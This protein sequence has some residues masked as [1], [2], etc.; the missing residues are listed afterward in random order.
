MV[1]YVSKILRMIEPKEGLVF[2]PMQNKPERTGRNILKA[3][4]HQD[5]YALIRSHGF[6]VEEVP[7]KYLLETF[8]E[9]RSQDAVGFTIGN[10]VYVA[11]DYRGRP[12]IRTEKNAIAYHEL[13]HTLKGSSETSA[14]RTGIEMAKSRGDYR[15]AN[16]MEQIGAYEGWVN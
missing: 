10:K 7:Q 14:Q 4:T 3:D 8:P 15:V 12:L 5:V 6:E 9:A 11:A 1:D 16:L 13:G 2:E